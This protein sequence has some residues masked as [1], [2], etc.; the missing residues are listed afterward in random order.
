MINLKIFKILHSFTHNDWINL[1]SY[2]KSSD[3]IM[4]RKYLPLILELK[5]YETRFSALKNISVSEIFERAYDKNFNPHT[6]FNRQSELLNLL[7]KFLEKTAYEKNTLNRTLFYFDELLSRNLIDQFSKEYK[8][9]DILENNHYD[10][11]LYKIL[12]KI[13]EHRSNYFALKN[14]S[15][16]SI[17]AY[18]KSSDVLL[19][20]ILSNLYRT[21][22]EFQILDYHYI[23][24]N[25][26]MSNFMDSID[27]DNFFDELEKQN[28]PIFIVPLVHYY[29]FK[30]LQCPDNK[31]YIFKAKRIFYKNEKHFPEKFRLH[32]YGKI[33]SYYYF[34][35]NKGDEGYFK[36]LFLLF[37]R[38]LKQNL[39]SD[40]KEHYF[41][42]NNVFCEYVITGLKVKQFDWVEMVIKK[43]SPLL[44]EEIR[45]DEYTLAMIRLHFA[46]KEYEK[47][48]E[49]IK[50]S[51]IHNKKHYLDSIY[52][53]LISNY[54]LENF[55]ECYKEIDNTR[56][57]L[58]N[59]RTNVLRVRVIPLKKFLLIFSKLLNY[60]MN[61]FNQDI[62]D[63][64]YEFEES[65]ITKENW[66][67]I[68]LQEISMKNNV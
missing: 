11:N 29:V 57:Y 46:K 4:G 9:R 28:K 51:K 52:Y 67:Y 36:D 40:F 5:N 26:S 25:N 65:G 37:K 24:K 56:H 10:E 18:L 54:E 3:K 68:K 63:I 55:E 20:E 45:E 21:G 27:S 44:P 62:N 14:E 35:I 41:I 22:Q 53:K 59:N 60:R 30:S 48:L 33:M 31:K 38:K 7:K 2:I 19:A 42:Y 8:K 32:I 39:V 64:F 58:K 49:I 12:S 17:N 15:E 23:N 66:E 13:I 16:N 6:I 50:K 47:T 61:P 34:K 43:Y 1:I